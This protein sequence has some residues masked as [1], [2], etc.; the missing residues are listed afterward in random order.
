MV[1]D[2]KNKMSPLPQ[3]ES[4]QMCIPKCMYCPSG[5]CQV[6]PSVPLTLHALTNHCGGHFD[7]R[8]DSRPAARDATVVCMWP[9][10]CINI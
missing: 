6:Q 1:S 3:P 10:Q 2:K 4:N 5:R 7:P 8:L 9:V